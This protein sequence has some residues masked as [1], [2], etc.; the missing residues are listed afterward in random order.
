M[1]LQYKGIFLGKRVGSKNI[2]Y[3]LHIENLL[4]IQ[5]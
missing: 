3:Q 2:V 5:Q 4:Q 1:K